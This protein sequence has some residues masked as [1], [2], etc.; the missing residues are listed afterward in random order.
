MVWIGEPVPQLEPGRG[1]L[2][3][4]G[5]LMGWERQENPLVRG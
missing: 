2:V 4:L 3:L 5:L 1:T